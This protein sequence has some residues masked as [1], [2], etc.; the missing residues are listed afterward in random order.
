MNPRAKSGRPLWLR[1]AERQTPMSL[2]AH[3]S[4]RLWPAWKY[5][6]RPLRSANASGAR[7]GWSTNLDRLCQQVVQNVAPGVQ[8]AP[9][10]C[11]SV[12]ALRSLYLDFSA[13]TWEQAHDL[14]ELFDQLRIAGANPEFGRLAAIYERYLE[15]VVVPYFDGSRRRYLEKSLKTLIVLRWLGVPYR[16]GCP[17]S[18]EKHK[19]LLSS[20]YVL[21]GGAGL[22]VWDEEISPVYVVETDQ[23]RF[24]EWI[25]ARMA[26]FLGR[27]DR[28]KSVSDALWSTLFSTPELGS[29]RELASAG[30]PSH[31]LRLSGD[32]FSGREAVLVQSPGAGARVLVFESPW[33]AD[34]GRR[35]HRVMKAWPEEIPSCPVWIWVPRRLSPHEQ[36]RI[37]RYMAIARALRGTVSGENPDETGE[38]LVRALRRPYLGASTSALKAIIDCYRQGTVVTDRGAWQPGERTD[39][40][41]HLIGDLATWASHE[42]ESHSLPR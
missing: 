36:E 30:S 19:S 8:A 7:E 17:I 2:G 12:G 22:M 35:V 3:H 21:C 40:L 42:G 15:P 20:L 18:A 25:V 9:W 27:S 10:V 11:Q 28:D 38:W 23:D 41:V 13:Q 5:L 29:E 16:S 4:A 26:A 37:T 32:V 24:V 6:R 34:Q 14:A 39:S 1:V 33:E 31:S